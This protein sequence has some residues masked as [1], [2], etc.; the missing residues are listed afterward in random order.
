MQLTVAI[1]RYYQSLLQKFRSE[2]LSA[3][4]WCHCYPCKPSLPKG[5]KYIAFIEKVYKSFHK[6]LVISDTVWIHAF[7]NS[8]LETCQIFMSYANFVMVVSCLLLRKSSSLPSLPPNR[9][10]KHLLFHIQHSLAKL[11][12]S[13]LNRL[14]YPIYWCPVWPLCLLFPFHILLR[15]TGQVVPNVLSSSASEAFVLALS[16]REAVFNFPRASRTFWLSKQNFII[17]PL[18]AGCT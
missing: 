17:V 3:F 1:L 12:L 5:Q 6:F 4:I 15:Y 7:P 16:K 13:I 11:I 10:I 2:Y 8:M 18:F 9:L 14:H